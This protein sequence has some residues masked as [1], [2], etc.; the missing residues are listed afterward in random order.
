MTIVHEITRLKYETTK[1]TIRVDFV[2]YH[3]IVKKEGEPDVTISCDRNIIE[4]IKGTFDH[5]IY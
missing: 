1:D 5:E 3:K 2:V 4:V